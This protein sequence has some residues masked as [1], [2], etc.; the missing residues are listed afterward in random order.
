MHVLLK[1]DKLW[2]FFSLLLTQ[3]KKREDFLFCSVYISYILVL[4]HFILTKEYISG[5]GRMYFQDNHGPEP[6]D[7]RKEIRKFEE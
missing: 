6:A 5:S 2:K 3:E 7:E 1:K 4:F